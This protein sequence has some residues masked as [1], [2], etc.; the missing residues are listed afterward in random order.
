M[1]VIPDPDVRTHR[2]KSQERRDLVAQAIEQATAN[3]WLGAIETNQRLL[4]ASGQDVEA[5][6]RLGKACAQIGRIPAAQAAYDAALR[7]DPD[8]NIARR[9]AARLSELAEL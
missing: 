6:N 7:I 9:N 4:D 1:S 3:E 8:N 5:Y 2:E